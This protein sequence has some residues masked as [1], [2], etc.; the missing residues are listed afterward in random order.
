MV[1]HEPQFRKICQN[2]KLHMGSNTIETD[3]FK[4][5]RLVSKRDFE[6]KLK[7]RKIEIY[8]PQVFLSKFP[9]VIQYDDY[10]KM[11]NELKLIQDINEL[12][13]KI[14]RENDPDKRDRMTQKLDESKAK[15]RSNQFYNEL[16]DL[17]QEEIQMVKSIQ[18]Q[19][20]SDFI[21][22]TL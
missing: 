9:H 12:N 21:L 6:K 11:I 19:H 13:E 20:I 14:G 18:V 4:G 8:V 5:V 1:N 22:S 2:L 10:I 17:S 16:R 15:M 3:I 7:S